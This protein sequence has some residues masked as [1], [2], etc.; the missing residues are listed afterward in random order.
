ML[1][2]VVHVYK[3]PLT[4]VE[5][6]F[7]VQAVHDILYHGGTVIAYDHLEFPGVVPRTFLGMCAFL[8]ERLDMYIVHV[9]FCC[10]EVVLLFNVPF[11]LVGA[12]VVAILSYPWKLLMDIYHV[13][14]IHI[15]LVSRCILACC[16]ALSFSY[17]ATCANQ[18]GAQQVVHIFFILTLLQFHMPF[19][20]SRFLPNTLAVV[21]TSIGLGDW[22][23][24]R[25]TT[26]AVF[27]LTLAAIVFRCDAIIM[28]GLVGLHMLYTGQIG[29]FKAVRVGIL[30]V[31]CSLVLSVG[32]DSYF[33]QRVL[34]P[35]GEVLWFN[36]VLNKYVRFDMSLLFLRCFRIIW[37][38]I[39]YMSVCIY[40]YL[41]S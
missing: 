5:E 25:H 22:I 2:A 37:Y 10:L 27:M 15:L 28:V 26:R 30:A 31:L 12:L 3:A 21:M 38:D 33:W 32:I 1:V 18:T 19:Y 29:F 24:G 7:N 14:K 16:V 20:M 23:S 40:C 41:R 13:S 9:Y 34:W 6:S 8:Y 36:T 39:F 4:K 35:E 17:F 11:L